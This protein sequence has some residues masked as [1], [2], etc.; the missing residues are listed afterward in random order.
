MFHKSKLMFR[1][2]VNSSLL[3]HTHLKHDTGEFCNRLL[4]LAPQPFY[5]DRGTPIAVSQLLLALS[6]LGYC[7]DVVTYP[8]GRDPKIKG[9][10]LFRGPNPL[11]FR[12]VPIGFSLRKIALDLGLLFPIYKQLRKQKY[13]CIHAVEE[14]AFLAVIFGRL[15]GLPVVYDMQSCL[16][17]Q[18]ANQGLSSVFL[19]KAVLQYFEKWLLRNVDWVMCSS[20]L[21]SRIR[22]IVPTVAIQEWFFFSAYRKTTSTE[23][24]ELRATLRIPAHSPVVVYTGTFEDYQGLPMLIDAIPAILSKIPNAVFVLVGD[25]CSKGRL[26]FRQ[27]RILGVQQSIRFIPRQKQEHIP[28]YL[29]LSDV[30]VSP[31][32]N[33]GNLPLK[34]FDYLAAVKPIVATDIPTHRT[35]LNEERAVLVTLETQSFADGVIWVLQNPV[36][37][38]SL[39]EKS[40]AYTEQQLGW[41]RF[42]KDVDFVYSR[43]CTR[44]TTV[45]A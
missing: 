31:R 23:V 38:K 19:G 35:L 1:L 32:L 18:L 15:F 36:E 7:V 6:Q 16:P 14:A 11:K 17:E 33:G 9:V 37:A 24:D 41:P 4:L 10:N 21:A 39:A 45:M 27:A 28:K 22:S 8:I 3:S 25:N 5:E 40:R 44:S 12:K 42:L 29:A 26:L 2:C 20:G 13:I 34:I 30:L 43:V